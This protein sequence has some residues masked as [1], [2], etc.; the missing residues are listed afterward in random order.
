MPQMASH[1]RRPPF[2]AGCESTLGSAECK[3]LVHEIERAGAFEAAL[4]TAISSESTQGAT[5]VKQVLQ[6]LRSGQIE[7]ADVPCPM[8][9]PGHLLIGSA[10]TLIS[11]GTERMLVEFGKGSL[12]AKAKSQPDKVKQVLDK[13]K[14]EGLLPTLDAVFSR[15]DEPLPLGYCNSGVVL[16]VGDGITGFKVGDRVVSN[17]N[18]AE[19]VCVPHTLCARIPDSVDDDSAAFTVLASIGLQGIRLIKPTL[20][21]SIVVTGLG[22][23]GLMTVQMLV[24]NGCRVLG[25]D[26]DPAKL[27]LA[28]ELGAEVVDLPNGADVVQTALAFSQGRGVDGVII[29]ASA[30]TNDIVKQAAQMSRK[31]GRIVLV[32]VVGLELSRSDFYQKE[33]TF[34]V[35]C[36]YG[37]GRY[38]PVY[39]EKGRDYPLGFVRWTEQR[40]FEAILALLGNKTLDVTKLID[41][42]IPQTEAQEAYK[43]LTEN[44]KILGIILE[45]PDSGLSRDTVVSAKEVRRFAASQREAVVGVIGA[46]NFSKMT[47]L[48]SIAKSN[49]RLACIA[50]LDGAA[51]AHAGRKFAA[52]RFTTDYKTMLADKDINALFVFTRHD[53]H[54][55]FVKECLLAGKSVF[56]EKPLCLNHAELDDLRQIYE[57]SQ[58]CQ[59]MVGFNRRFSPHAEKI[60]SLLVGRTEPVCISTMINAGVI[61]ATGWV[62][63]PKIGGGRII[64][65]GCHWID[66][67]MFLIGA[68]ITNVSSM[69]VGES[70]AVAVRDDKMTITLTFADGSI[71]TLHYFGNGHKAY[72]KET[73]EVFVD[74]KVLRMDNFRDLRG[75]GWTGFS[76]MKLRRMDKGHNAEFHRFVNTVAQGG[77]PLIPFHEIDNVMKATFAAV[78]AAESGKTVKIC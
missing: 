34:Q 47:A 22:L 54:A 59:L 61:P 12:I 17:G 65:E 66:L 30:K 76:R 63:D 74:G 25:I 33:L 36:S 20:G 31:R 68:P 27:Q 72:P 23:I 37:P 4:Q 41:K 53:M 42:R 2:S 46:G 26:I 62:H 29:T 35:S 24:A 1:L 52:E 70:P 60:K 73:M 45:Y 39:E 15:L 32:G 18:H 3:L 11:A 14:T 75:Y 55:R 43:I 19:V 16:E 5:F 28:R 51:A 56:V 77:Q 49:A 8:V 58:N 38:D 7:V 71:G 44:P 21:E 67:M 64:G 9:R 6:H 10:R 13:I 50:D 48:P 78:E 69:K 40:N 57:Q